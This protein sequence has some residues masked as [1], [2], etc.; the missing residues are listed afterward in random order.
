MAIDEIGILYIFLDDERTI[1]PNI[2]LNGSLDIDWILLVREFGEEMF[3]EFE[4][5]EQTFDRIE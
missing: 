5:V 3:F 1:S 2:V 4:Q